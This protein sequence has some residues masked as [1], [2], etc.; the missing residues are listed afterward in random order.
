LS[1]EEQEVYRRLLAR[2]GEGEASS[3]AA[4]LERKGTVV[5]DDRAARNVRREFEIALSGTIGILVAGVS[6]ALLT[7]AAADE[8]LDAMVE[9]GFHSPVRRISDIL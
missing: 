7:H 2:L 3:I 9:A 5:T 4:A 6:D 8:I 1:R